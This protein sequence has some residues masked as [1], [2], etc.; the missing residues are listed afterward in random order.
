VRTELNVTD[1]VE[2][3]AEPGTTLFAMDN[4]VRK[5]RAGAYIRRQ[6]AGL[7]LFEPPLNP[8]EVEPPPAVK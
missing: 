6:S 5:A 1:P 7:P 4:A 3:T 8:P 2:R